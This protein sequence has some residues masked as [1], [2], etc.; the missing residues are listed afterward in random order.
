MEIRKTYRKFKYSEVEFLLLGDDI[1]THLKGCE[2][3]YIIAATLGGVDEELRF[4]GY[5]DPV[6]ALFSES[7]YNQTI[8]S[9]VDEL[10]KTIKQ[11]DRAYTTR[12]SPGYGDFPL[13]VQ[14][15]IAR[16]LDTQ[17]RI[18][19]TVTD[20]DMLLPRKSITALLGEYPICKI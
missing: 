16:L 6:K 5:A 8:E 10:E 13:A 3:I 9:V 12:Y 17:R 14:R 15:E 1:K 4:L 18:G 7:V 11:S 20:S 2:F 19:M